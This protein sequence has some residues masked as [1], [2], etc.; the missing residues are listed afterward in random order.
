MTFTTEYSEI[1]EKIHTI[2]PIKYGRS[3]NFID[4]A[5]TYLS[6]YISRGVISTKQ[7][8][9]AILEKNNHAT[10]IE[11]LVQELA[12]RDYWQQ[13]WIH[14]KNEIDFDLKNRQP[15]VRNKGISEVIIQGKTGIEAIDTAIELFYTTGYLH[16][17][18]R[19]YIAFLACNASKS[20]WKVPAQWMYYHL[21]DADWASNAL[22]WQ[23]VAGANS[24]K[25]YVANQDNINKYCHTNQKNT[26]VDIE[27]EQLDFPDIPTILE[28]TITIPLAT[29]LPTTATPILQPGIPTLLYNFYNMD[30][31]WHQNANVNRILLLEPSVFSKY[32]VS[33][34]S[35]AFCLSLGKNIPNLQVYVGEFEDLQSL[36]PETSFIFKEHPLNHYKGKEES[37]DWM[38]GVE[39]YYPSFFA[40][41]KKCQKEFLSH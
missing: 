16:N 4:G 3:R 21:L 30:P 15:D 13:I 5:V 41:W 31:L 23:W 29:T 17:H 35:I 32:P 10:D 24:N 37:R 11:K 14:K 6:P 12:W 2:D 27:Y 9:Q 36:F 7:V 26:F 20:H 34:K 18:V 39:G 1:V 25:K 22:S 40:F 33:A 19:M 8:Y 38:F 28:K